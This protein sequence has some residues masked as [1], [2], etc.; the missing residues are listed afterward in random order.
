MPAYDFRCTRGHVTEHHVGRLVTKVRCAC[1]LRAQRVLTARV[2]ISGLRPTPTAQARIP[3]SRY[4]EAQGE[5]VESARR[6]GVEPPD[7]WKAAKERIR[8]GDVKA[9]T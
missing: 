1:G 8:R 7:L 3:F 9:I 6:H 5:V 2:G 4:L